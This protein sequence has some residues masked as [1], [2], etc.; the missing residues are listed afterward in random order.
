MKK[1]ADL[2]QLQEV[3]S[4]LSFTRRKLVAPLNSAGGDQLLQAVSGVESV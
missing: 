1:I 4:S 3:G 2:E